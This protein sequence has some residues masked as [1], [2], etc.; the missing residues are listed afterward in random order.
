MSD[1]GEA[2]R[3]LGVEIR[4][5]RAKRILSLSQ[6]AYTETILAR[7]KLENANPLT[8]PMDPVNAY[9]RPSHPACGMERQYVVQEGEGLDE[10]LLTAIGS[11]AGWHTRDYDG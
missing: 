10:M 5:D 2:H 6:G 4:R 9:R 11:A 1:L 8:T 3:L 7:F